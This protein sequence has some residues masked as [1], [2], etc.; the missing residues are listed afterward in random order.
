M[1][2]I[3]YNQL[4]IN[5]N[6]KP[7]SDL[8]VEFY[9]QDINTSILRF[10]I[11]RCDKNVN[12][13][14]VKT[15]A[16]IMLVAKDGSKV[17]DYLNIYDGENGVVSYKIPTDFLK[18]TGRV[19]GQ[20]Y[21]YQKG[22]VLVTRTFSFIIKDSLINEFTAE[23]KLE[24]IK[25]YD[26]L[27]TIIKNKVIKIDE[28]IKNGEDYVTKMEVILETGDSHIKETVETV[29]DNLEKIVV[30]ANADITNSVEDGKKHL[31]T[32]ADNTIKAVNE[33]AKTIFDEIENKQ[34]VSVTDTKEWQK[35][36]VWND[37]GSSLTISGYDLLN[38]T[39]IQNFDGYVTVATNSPTT[40]NSGYFKRKYRDG[41]VEVTYAPHSTKDVY[42]NS[43][44]ASLKTWIGWERVSRS[45]ETQN[46]KI[47]TDSGAPKYDLPTSKD[48]FAEASAWG[49]GLHTFYLS[50]GATNNPAGKASHIT[51][52]AQFYGNA[53]GITAFD[54]S[55]KQYYAARTGATTFSDW[56]DYSSTDSGWISY[57]VLNGVL[58]NTQFMSSDGKGF[59]CS[60]RSVTQQG[61]TTKYLRINMSKFTNGLVV[62]QLPPTFAENTQNFYARTAVSWHAITVRLAA[63]GE[64]SVFVKSDDRAQ[65]PEDGY[66]YQE[67][68]WVD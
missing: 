4:D 36:K 48:L 24:Y 10:G 67:F 28:A 58:P 61:V 38:V 1:K 62:A 18:H 53:G 54:K 9:D 33:K 27:E 52:T 11:T 55:G 50:A 21:V 66:I 40:R 37:D 60:Y 56:Q 47:T 22:T 23:T 43:Y 63:N 32:A 46:V 5:S 3:S 6:L 2:K 26:D 45:S 59:S 29:T 65:W 44:N 20:V 19:L 31:E 39:D 34:I 25:T 51:G 16:Y 35:K 57:N 64:V 68:S 14:T 12:L 15:D 30:N 17:S 13:T 49:N 42:R 7:L 41:Y 8:N